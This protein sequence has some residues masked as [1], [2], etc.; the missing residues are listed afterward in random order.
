M[1]PMR[2]RV[3]GGPPPAWSLASPASGTTH[4]AHVWPSQPLT[5]SA[6]EYEAFLAEQN[7]V[8]STSGRDPMY[9]ATP[10]EATDGC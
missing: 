8:Y 9:L 6:A 1:V 2:P 10:I 3:A 4:G 7:L 5:L